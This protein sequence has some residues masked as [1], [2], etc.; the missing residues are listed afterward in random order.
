MNPTVPQ[1]LSL[2]AHYLQAD[3]VM[4]GVLWL[5][6]LASLALASW[7]GTWAQALVVGGGT[8]MVMHGL[9]AL[10]KGGRLFRCA[11]GAAFMVMAALHINQ[12]RGTMEMHFSIFVLLAFL[13]YY[14]DWM[15]ILVATLV[16][17]VHHLM[18]FYLQSRLQGV[19]LAPGLTFG[20]VFVHAG[21]VVVEAAVLIYL[22]QLGYRDALEGEAMG[23]ATAMM[24]VE[25]ERVDLTYRVAMRTPMV[26]SFNRFVGG[27]D[28]MVADVGDSLEQLGEV[29]QAV[30]GKSVAVRQ[31]AERQQSETQYM[32]QAMQELGRATAEVARN[33]ADAAAASEGAD[34]H[35]QQGYRAMEGIRAEV[36]SLEENIR[37]TGTAV[38]GAAQLAV[39]I[40][41]VVDVI[42]SVAEQT[43]L[44]A[45]NAA[46][47]AARAGEHGRGFAVVADEVRN[48]S[49]RT[50]RSTAEI[51][52]FISRLQRASEQA[53]GAMERSQ[54][55]V[56]RCISVTEN[57]AQI[58]SGIVAEIASIANLNTTIA[59]ATQEQASVGDD[60]AKHLHGI[61]DIATANADQAV[62][63]ARLASELEA[64]RGQLNDQVRQFATKR[65]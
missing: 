49:Q 64:V 53:R 23:R 18:F 25:G 11:I 21:Y 52:D 61:G 42:K 36:N 59:A 13:I 5:C 7:Y 4:L 29:G 9:H 14:R 33:A 58:L 39:D 45:L 46:I 22:A 16:I 8:L 56:E 65:G 19:W 10:G 26:D 62:E 40:D 48:L 41:Q 43:N 17:A 2:D 57:S 35:A 31:S 47:E 32:V 1:S 20:L 3:R 34:G 63:L 6:M 51:Q 15:P 27:L 24:M 50:A 44:L 55:S 37:L 60:V 28:A 38:D 30:T 54:D 12:S